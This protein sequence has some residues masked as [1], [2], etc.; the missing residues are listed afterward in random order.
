MS[1]IRD[2]LDENIVMPVRE[3]P[4]PLAATAS[5]LPISIVTRRVHERPAPLSAAVC[6]LER[7][8]EH[9]GRSVER[10]AGSRWPASPWRGDALCAPAGHREAGHLEAGWIDE[11]PAD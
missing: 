4:E 7:I 8:R 10:P 3:G 1:W 6:Q 9:R 5:P 2:V 11:R